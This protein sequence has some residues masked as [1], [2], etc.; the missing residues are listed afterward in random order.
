M[1]LRMRCEDTPPVFLRKRRLPAP[2]CM[3]R[4]AAANMGRPAIDKG[5]PSNRTH[6]NIDILI[7][8]I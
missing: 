2:V 7:L 8:I 3:N 6:M 1:L 5:G 4:D